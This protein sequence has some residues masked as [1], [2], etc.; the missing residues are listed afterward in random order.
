[1]LALENTQVLSMLVSKTL[2]SSKKHH[3]ACCPVWNHTG[4]N[5]QAFLSPQAAPQIPGLFSKRFCPKQS[6]CR[7]EL[8]AGLSLGTIHPNLCLLQRHFWIELWLI[9][10]RNASQL[11][12]KTQTR[13]KE[14]SNPWKIVRC[15]LLLLKARVQ[16]SQLIHRQTQTH[17]VSPDSYNKMIPGTTIFCFL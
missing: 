14:G 13:Q 6:S 7:S 2:V 15:L 11:S 3:A 12:T 1:M 4:T 16:K 9:F 8:Q 17:C 5:S 10:I